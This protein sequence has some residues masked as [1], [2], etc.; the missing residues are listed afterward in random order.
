MIIVIILLLLNLHLSFG[1]VLG[2]DL[3][4]EFMKVA[5]VAPGTPFKIVLDE[6]SKRKVPVTIG[7]D[8]DIRQ[9]GN[10]AKSLLIK[11]PHRAYT[12]ISRLLGKPINCNATREITEDLGFPFTFVEDKARKTIRV[13][14]SEEASYSVEELVAMILTYARRMAEVENDDKEILDAVIT[15]PEYWSQKE[16][17]ALLDAASIADLK[18]LSLINENTAAGVEYGIERSY[19]VDKVEHFIFF[20][21]GSTSTKVSLMK[22]SAYLSKKNK[23]LGQMEVIATAWDENLGGNA[24]DQVLIAD[25]AEAVGKDKQILSQ[26][27]EPEKLGEMPKVMARLRTAAR[28]AKEVLNANKDYF[29]NIEGV[30]KDADL[31]GHKIT[32]EH[33]YHLAQKQFDR[34]LAPV[35]KVVE[36]SGLEKDDITNIVLM[37]GTSRIPGIKDIL[38]KYLPDRELKKDLNADEA[39]AFGAAFAAAN[40]STSFRVRPIGIVDITPYPVGVR[41]IDLDYK[42]RYEQ[43]LETFSKRGTLYKRGNKLQVTKSMK[44]THARSIR[45]SAHYDE[46]ETLPDGT[47][48]WIGKWNI[49]GVEKAIKDFEGKNTT[50]NPKIMLSFKLDNNGIVKLDRA[51]AIFTEYYEAPVKPKKEEAKKDKKDL[52]EAEG[53]A[54]EEGK[55]AE[56]EGKTAEAAE[57]GG[58]EQT[59]AAEEGGA[60]P[61][62]A[63]EGTEDSPK[64]VEEVNDQDREPDGE[65]SGDTTSKN[66]MEKPS[67]ESEL[68]EDESVEMEVKKK[69]HKI[70]LK[71][72]HV[73]SD[74]KALTSEG[75]KVSK[76]V[77]MDLDDLDRRVLETGAAKN[78][79]ESYIFEARNR[80]YDEEEIEKVSTEEQQEAALAPLQDAEDWL[81]DVEPEDESAGLYKNKLRTIRELADKIFGRAYQYKHREK[82]VIDAYDTLEV[83]RGIIL[84]LQDDM[85]WVPEEDRTKLAE[86]IDKMEKWLKEKVE[87]QEGLDV[88]EEP[89]LLVEQISKKLEDPTKFADK[90]LRRPKPKPKKK[91][92]DKKKKKTG[93]GEEDGEEEGDVESQGDDVATSDEKSESGSPAEE[94]STDSS[95]G[96]DSVASSETE[97]GKDSEPLPDESDEKTEL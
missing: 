41:I 45:V 4:S 63:V 42:D 46:A 67:G 90:L 50:G 51:R 22:Y 57:D 20:N 16:R 96:D 91:K 36:I 44:F 49:T 58:E 18:V 38:E 17:Q 7:F 54:K 35:E 23:T 87:E 53:K 1:A 27:Y 11:R 31:R 28:K 12:Y 3:G 37:G 70:T 73:G 26:G 86:K 88:T 79:L 47:S 72:T 68:A 64:E 30:F 6:T 92:K 48:A 69:V 32:R 10:V 59:A 60:D 62:E 82:A 40:I 76:K 25:I 13:Q 61:S 55:T 52:K 21:S 8:D 83:T 85:P 95:M 66:A 56:Q 93:E 9:F 5:L 65:S 74:L 14:L 71:I 33:F 75:V 15:V 80:F 94:P 43:G 34:V 29:V 19:D 89:V 97:N 39:S 24:F 81:W 78:A 2:I 77:L 84:K